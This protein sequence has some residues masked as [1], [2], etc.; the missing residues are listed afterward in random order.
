M[1][2]WSYGLGLLVFFWLGLPRIKN[3]QKITLRAGFVFS[4]RIG[5][6]AVLDFRHSILLERAVNSAESCGA[7]TTTTLTLCIKWKTDC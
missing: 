3:P 5:R 1:G 7:D 2:F 4:H 6:E